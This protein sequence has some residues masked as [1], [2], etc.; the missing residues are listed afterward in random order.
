M[1]LPSLTFRSFI[2]LHATCA[3]LLGD[4]VD[5]HQDGESGP[6]CLVRRVAKAVS[7]G[8]LP[9][10]F[11]WRRLIVSKLFPFWQDDAAIFLEGLSRLTADCAPVRCFLA[12][13]FYHNWGGAETGQIWL[14]T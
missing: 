4:G 10:H 8:R 9:H 2:S 7:C 5:W 11:S 1:P 6:P 12:L 14:V 3:K 13:L